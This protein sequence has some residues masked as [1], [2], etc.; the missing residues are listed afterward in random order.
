MNPL[1]RK[2]FAVSIALSTCLW[3]A[4]CSVESSPVLWQMSGQTVKGLFQVD[5]NCKTEPTIGEFQACSLQILQA[6]G[7]AVVGATVDLDGGM[8]A[9][10]HGLPTRPVVTALDDHGHYQIEGL[11]YSMPGAWLL[12]FLIKSP[13]GQDKIVFDFVI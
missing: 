3:L 12:G 13:A 5:L 7:Q 11:Q 9:H 4:G 2:L 1:K 10:G 8:P 6:N